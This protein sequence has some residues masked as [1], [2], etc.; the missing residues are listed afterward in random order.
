MIIEKLTQ[1]LDE[2][3]NKL[4]EIDIKNIAEFIEHNEFGVAYE[5]LCVQVYE[6]EVEISEGFY[7]ELF[8]CGKSMQIDPVYYEPLKELIR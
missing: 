1:A 3:I 8:F 2:V 6:Y 7:E 5:L 4:P